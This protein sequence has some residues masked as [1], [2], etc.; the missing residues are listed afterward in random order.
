MQRFWIPNKSNKSVIKNQSLEKCICDVFSVY[1]FFLYL[2]R[3]MDAH[4]YR[5]VL[6][7]TLICLTLE[8]WSK[9]ILKISWSVSCT[10]RVMGSR[11]NTAPVKLFVEAIK[12]LSLSV[13]L[14]LLACSLLFHLRF[15][16]LMVDKSTDH[17]NLIV[18]ELLNDR[19]LR[20]Q[21]SKLNLV[22][23]SSR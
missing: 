8:K 11:F 7:F 23:L 17:K 10:L 15:G 4:A 6:P 22:S 21:V 2:Y 18:V 12:H 9:L 19:S 3:T 13:A 1:F 16:L 20:K 5:T 14:K